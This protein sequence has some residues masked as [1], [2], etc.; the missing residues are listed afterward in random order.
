[1]SLF[2]ATYSIHIEYRPPVVF[3][4]VDKDEMSNLL[5]GYVAMARTQ[6]ENNVKVVRSDKGFELT[7]KPMQKFY[8]DHGIIRQSS[9]VNTPHR[10]VELKGN[11]DMS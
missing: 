5:K 7:S 4:M 10:M 8:E 2:I 1:M 9:C 6:F 11:I 3:L